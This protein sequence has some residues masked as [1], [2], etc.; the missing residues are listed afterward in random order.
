MEQELVDMKNYRKNQH[1]KTSQLNAIGGG[2]VT[3]DNGEKFEII[4][5]EVN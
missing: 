5:E 1:I 4:V 3:E 2:I